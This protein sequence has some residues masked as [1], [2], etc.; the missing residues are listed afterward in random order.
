MREGKGEGRGDSAGKGEKNVRVMMVLLYLP[1]SLT[2]L[3]NLHED[4]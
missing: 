4:G 2:F 1:P 3:L